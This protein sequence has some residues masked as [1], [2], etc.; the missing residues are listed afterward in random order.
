MQTIYGYWFWQVEVAF[1]GVD[2]RGEDTKSENSAMKV[3]PPWMIK[4][5][6]NLTKEQRGEVKEEMKMEGTSAPVDLPEDKKDKKSMTQNTDA[7]ILQASAKNNCLSLF[8]VFL[9]FYYSSVRASLCT[10]RH[11]WGPI[12]PR[13]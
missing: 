11:S 1:P 13:Q 2:E 3:L 4:Q 7:K 5:G 9:F 12:P 8:F 6:M 10:P